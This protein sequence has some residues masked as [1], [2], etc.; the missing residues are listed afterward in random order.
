MPEQTTRK[1]ID[2][3]KTTKERAAKVMGE[4]FPGGVNAWAFH[5]DLYSKAL[6]LFEKGQLEVLGRTVTKSNGKVSQQAG[7]ST[8]G[9]LTN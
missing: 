2:V 9:A 4:H 3:L 1:S 7:R 8:E 6:D 5:D